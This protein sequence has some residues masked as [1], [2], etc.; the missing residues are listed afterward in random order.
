MTRRMP[1]LPLLALIGVNLAVGGYVGWIKWL[2]AVWPLDDSQAARL[3]TADWN[4]GAVL[5]AGDAIVSALVLTVVFWAVNWLVTRYVRAVDG[6]WA[7]RLACITGGLVLV[8]G[9]VGALQFWI[10]KPWY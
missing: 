2:W 10:T 4:A 8:G 5:R 7:R 3:T 9:V 1:S 6:I